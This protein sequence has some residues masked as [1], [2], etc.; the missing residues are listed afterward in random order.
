VQV[1]FGPFVLDV[2][3][4]QLMQG[5]RDLHLTPKAFDLLAALVAN[6]PKALS[7]SDLHQRLW[8]GTFVADA[9]L[10]NLIAEVR[11]TLGDQ[12]QTPLYIRTVHRFGYAFCADATTLGDERGAEDRRAQCWLRYGQRQ[13]PLV[14]GTNVIGRDPDVEVMLDT[15]TVSR[16][17]A[18]VV[19]TPEGATLEDLG[20]KNGTFLGDERIRSPV[21][22]ADGAT[23][24]L[25]SLVVTYHVRHSLDATETEAC[26]D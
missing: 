8:P 25:G 2:D 23:I 18:Q 21:A 11:Q 26:I 20:S 22:L 16:R 17:H 7:K 13:F 6:R 14:V 19:V 24:G 1:Q 4:R 12:A 5:R 15:S 10:A 9:N 3:S